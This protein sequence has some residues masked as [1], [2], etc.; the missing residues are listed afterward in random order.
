MARQAKSVGGFVCLGG[1]KVRSFVPSQRI[2]YLE[3]KQAFLHPGSGRGSQGFRFFPLPPWAL[4][5]ALPRSAQRSTSEI[6][7]QAGRGNLEHALQ[8]SLG[9]F[10]G[11][12]GEHHVGHLVVAKSASSAESGGLGDLFQITQGLLRFPSLQQPG[13]GHDMVA[14][15]VAEGANLLVFPLHTLVVDLPQPRQADLLL[16]GLMVCQ[17]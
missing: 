8:P 13:H 9:H 11:L 15:V 10:L 12:G 7:R 1:G 4:S 5:K 6:K 16:Q 17:G 3:H 2:F 14:Q